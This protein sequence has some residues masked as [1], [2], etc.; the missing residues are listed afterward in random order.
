MAIKIGNKMVGENSNEQ[1]KLEKKRFEA[2][3]RRMEEDNVQKHFKL[4][5]MGEGNK[6]LSDFIKK[7]D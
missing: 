4:L 1:L 6:K 7:E 5:M 3:R 2:K